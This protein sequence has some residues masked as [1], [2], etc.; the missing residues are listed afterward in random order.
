MAQHGSD[1]NNKAKPTVKQRQES[2]I[3]QTARRS[4]FAPTATQNHDQ[5]KP[6]WPK[7]CSAAR[8]TSYPLQPKSGLSS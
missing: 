1:I 3:E 7:A 4:T 2:R 6:G 8:S 5:S